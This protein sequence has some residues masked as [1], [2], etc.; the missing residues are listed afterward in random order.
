MGEEKMKLNP[1]KGNGGHVTGYRV[2]IGSKEA[3]DAG[4]LNPDGTG[5]EIRKTVD[6]EK[7]RI[8]IELAEEQGAE[9]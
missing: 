9:V 2:I 4:L 1:N 6:P 8:I 5:K 7:H 3:R